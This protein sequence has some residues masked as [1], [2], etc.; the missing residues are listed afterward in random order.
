MPEISNMKTIRQTAAKYRDSG[1]CDKAI[2]R[3]V[4]EQAFPI[5]KIGVKVIINQKIFEQFL[6]GAYQITDERY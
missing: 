3:W 1:I 5:V 2:R 4:K 6:Q